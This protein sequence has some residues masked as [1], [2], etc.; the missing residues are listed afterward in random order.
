MSTFKEHVIQAPL[1]LSYTSVPMNAL[2]TILTNRPKYKMKKKKEF[3]LDK[4]IFYT[5]PPIYIR[6]TAFQYREWVTVVAASTVM[7][8]AEVMVVVR[9]EA[10]IEVLLVQSQLKWVRNMMWT[11]QK[12]A[13]K[14]TVLQESRGL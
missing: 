12:S 13:G 14:E 1:E 2:K 5:N 4:F 11:S 9:E 6:T 10:S 7:A 3:R 8:E